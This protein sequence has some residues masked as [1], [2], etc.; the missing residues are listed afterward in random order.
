[1]RFDAG[2]GMNP[3]KVEPLTSRTEDD[4]LAAMREAPERDEPKLVYADWLLANGDVRGELI[5]LD[6][7]DRTT[8]GI[9]DADRLWQLLVLSAEHGF[10]RLPDDPDSRILP[11]RGGGSFPV[12]YELDHEGHD[13][14]LRWRY[15]FSIDV[16]HETVLECDLDLQDNEW[17]DEQTNVM[18]AIVSEAI[19]AGAPLSELTFPD[20]AGFRAH[21]SHRAGPCPAYCLPDE[22]MNRLDLDP[23]HFTLLARD[24]GRWYDLW[25]R[26]KRIGSTKR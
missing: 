3:I 4:L 10:L 14:Y 5:V 11:F 22:F 26:F 9:Q 15:G 20:A 21:P 24:R 23:L 2:R 6:H 19:R 13:Y 8:G 18:L 17:T 1:M 16:D 12:Q 7:Q 25:G